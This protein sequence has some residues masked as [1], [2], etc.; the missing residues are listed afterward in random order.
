MYISEL[1]NGKL[2]R[3]H[4]DFYTELCFKGIAEMDFSSTDKL[5]IRYI[6]INL[7]KTLQATHFYLFH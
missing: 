7:L 5:D 4:F 1:A 2:S 6:R 3:H